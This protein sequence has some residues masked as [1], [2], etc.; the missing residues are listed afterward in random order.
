[1]NQ[2]LVRFSLGLLWIVVILNVLL[3]QFSV[4]YL[5][6]DGLA[7]FNKY[8][9]VITQMTSL[10]F[11]LGLVFSSYLIL[12]NDIR[13][14]RL[15]EISLGLLFLSLI[16]NCFYNYQP[17][18][19]FSSLFDTGLTIL[20]VLYVYCNVL[21]DNKKYEI[22]DVR[23][24]SIV[25]IAL[26]II[27]MLM[28]S[29]TN[30]ILALDDQTFPV[31]KLDVKIP[32]VFESYLLGIGLYGLFSVNFNSMIGKFCVPFLF[33]INLQNYFCLN[34]SSPLFAIL[35]YSIAYYFGYIIGL[36]YF[37]EATIDFKSGFFGRMFLYFW[38][39]V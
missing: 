14:L 33:I 32:G 23:M 7:I 25:L 26:S 8:N 39:S 29:L 30:H 5:P 9:I 6:V 20:G 37:S 28:P 2:K 22:G 24:T 38:L 34:V 17:Y 18:V 31:F 16:I 19:R 15:I 13:A 36:L 27:P 11:I 10:V 3:I 12:K 1:M 4:H 21:I 35:D